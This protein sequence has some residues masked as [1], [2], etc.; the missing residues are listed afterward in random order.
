MLHMYVCSS[1]RLVILCTFSNLECTE[2]VANLESMISVC[3]TIFG[4]H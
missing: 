4:L 1:N 3:Y 2:N